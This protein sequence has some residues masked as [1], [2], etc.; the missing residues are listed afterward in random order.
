[1]FLPTASKSI[2][3]SFYLLFF[4]FFFRFFCFSKTRKR[5]GNFSDQKKWQNKL[6]MKSHKLNNNNKKGKRLTNKRAKKE[7][8]K[9]FWHFC[10]KGTKTQNFPD[11]LF[12]FTYACKSV[13]RTRSR[14]IGWRTSTC[15][16]SLDLLVDFYL[17]FWIL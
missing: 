4:S 16:L 14:R 6:I 9:F 8:N 1:M 5:Q 12:F 7:K 11:L 13:F 2:L 17:L 3:F 15:D 10:N